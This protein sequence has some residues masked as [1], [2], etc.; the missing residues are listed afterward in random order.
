[1]APSMAVVSAPLTAEWR[2]LVMLSYEIDPL[3][4]VRYVPAGTSLDF[5]GGR[6]LVTM[7]GGRA[8]NLR[9]AGLPLPMPQGIARLDLRVPVW[10]QVGREVRRGVVFIKEIVPRAGVT[11]GPWF[12]FNEHFLTAPVRHQTA[13]AAHAWAAYE[14][15]ESSRWHRVSI[16]RRGRAAAPVSGSVEAFVTDRPWVYSRRRDG[17]TLEYR[18]DQTAVPTV[19]A[20]ASLDCDVAACFGPQLAG[21]LAGPAMS[22]LTADGGEAALHPA[23]PIA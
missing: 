17:S 1:M 3:L 4:L 8:L 20:E 18:I 22:A 2:D 23:E 16:R 6:A 21:T 12:H 9:V 15:R 14:W 19:A 5:H 13:A 11:L 10:R 7:T